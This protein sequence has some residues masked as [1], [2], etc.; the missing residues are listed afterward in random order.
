MGNKRPRSPFPQ[1]RSQPVA[2]LILLLWSAAVSADPP[3]YQIE[4]LGTLGGPYSRARAI[5]SLGRIVG[6]AYTSG[7]VEH[8]FLWQNDAMS[9]LGTLGGQRSRAFDINISG[10]AVGWA[11]NATGT[12]KPALWQSGQPIELPT[13]GG[14]SGTAWAVNDSGRAVGNAFLSQST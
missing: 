5:S 12:T 10:Q 11:Q 3:E 4:A 6:E 13:L 9:D 2:L 7:N 14:A 8:A 1:P